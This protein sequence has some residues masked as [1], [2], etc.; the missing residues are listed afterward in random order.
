MFWIITRLSHIEVFE[1]LNFRIELR[2][3]EYLNIQM[4]SKF[5]F[6]L[7]FT[8]FAF[9]GTG[10]SIL[11]DSSYRTAGD[12]HGKA[13]VGAFER[14]NSRSGIISGEIATLRVGSLRY[15]VTRAVN[16]GDLRGATLAT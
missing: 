16:N 12:N 4:T 13:R 14:V 11:F 15:R 10:I 5:R 8:H 6:V 9:A 1:Y 7:Q 3:P 2:Y